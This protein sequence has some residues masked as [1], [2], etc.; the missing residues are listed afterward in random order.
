[1]LL[2]PGS[3]MAQAPQSQIRVMHDSPDAPAVDVFVDGN[4]AF[5]NV[6]YSTTTDYQSLAPGRHRVQVAPTGESAEA[7]VIDTNVD[8]TGGKPYTVLALGRLA[9]IRAEVLPDTSKEPPAGQARV[10]IIHAAADTGPVDIYPTGSTI[11]LLT[12]QYLGSADYVNIPAGTY[13][14]DVTPAGTTQVALTSQEL[15]F[16]PGWVYTLTITRADEAGA[17]VVRASIDRLA[18]GTT[19]AG[20]S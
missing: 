5:E 19:P 15:K 2:A 7:S 12:D 4:L 13:T 16:E 9:D 10:R 17:P 1:L 11:P 3:T 8:L 6:G 20:Q 14:F 18:N